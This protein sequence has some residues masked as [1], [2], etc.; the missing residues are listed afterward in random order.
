GTARHPG[1]VLDGL[2]TPV[3]PATASGVLIVASSVHDEER[4]LDALHRAARLL[5]VR[6]VSV[7]R[8]SGP[9]RVLRHLDLDLE[10]LARRTGL[11]LAEP[12]VRGLLARIG[13]QVRA[14]R[15]GTVAVMV[16]D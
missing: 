11:S 4:C 6:P 3:D 8:G 12:D 13:A 2:T 14:D 15:D 1:L 10:L 9:A 7:S 5:G 16:P